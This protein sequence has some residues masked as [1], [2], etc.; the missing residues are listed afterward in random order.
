VVDIFQLFAGISKY[1]G[2]RTTLTFHGSKR[3]HDRVQ[4]H[5]SFAPVLTTRENTMSGIGVGEEKCFCVLRPVSKTS[6]AI[7]VVRVQVVHPLLK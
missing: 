1:R 4:A 5:V 6:A 7:A 3:P 2:H